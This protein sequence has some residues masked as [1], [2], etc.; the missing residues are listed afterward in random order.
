MKNSYKL[1]AGII[2]TVLIASQSFAATS[3]IVSRA[4]WKADESIRYV[5]NNKGEIDTSYEE[6]DVVKSSS[7][8]KKVI[9]EN[10]KGKEYKWPLQYP[11]KVERF[12]IHH[13]A[14]SNNPK[15]PMASIRSIYAYHAITR[16]WGDI[17]YNYIIDQNG[18]VYEGRAGGAG[19]VGGHARGYN[20][21]SIGIAILGNYQEAKVPKKAEEAL[22]N[23]IAVK[24]KEFKIDPAGY[25][26]VNGKKK[27]NVLGH[28][29]VASTV[30]PGDN[31]YEKLPSI[32]KAAAK[33]GNSSS[34]SKSTK[35][36]SFEEASDLYSLELNPEEIKEVTLKLENTGKKDWD[37]NTYILVDSNNAFEKVISFPEEQNYV[38]GK[39]SGSS[40]KSG[41]T[42]TFT[43]KIKGGE[44]PDTV[45]MK[46]TVMANG[47]IKISDYFQLPVTLN[48]SQY[49]YKLVETIFPP[50][51]MKPG[52]TFEATVKLKNM[53]N[54]SWKNAG[55]TAVFLAAD[56]ERGRKSEFVFPAG[57]KMGV[58]QEKE[59][60]PG[61]TGTF[62]M[63]LKAPTKNGLY[64]EYFT[65]V[66]GWST[67]MDDK[68]MN[69]ETLIGASD[70]GGKLVNQA[71]NKRWQ[72]GK[73]YTMWFNIKNMGSTTWTNKNFE[74]AFIKE[75]DLTVSGA[76]ILNDKLDPG[77]TGRVE[78]TVIIDPKDELG[79]KSM[80]VTPMVDGNYVLKTPI[81]FEYTTV[82]TDGKGTAE[83]RSFGT[84]T[85]VSKTTTISK[86]T[87][88][89]KTTSSTKTTTTVKKSSGKEGD[90]RI[91]LTF[92]GSPE[93]TASGNFEVKSGKTSLGKFTK[94]D[95][96]KV[97]N[98]NGDYKVTAGSKTYTK[99]SPIRF[100]PSTGSILKVN[101]F[102][103]TDNEF[104]E[105]LEVNMV[106]DELVLINELALENYMKGLAEEMN[107]TP[108][109]KIKAIIV[110]ARTY[111]KYYMDEADKFP[112]KPYN[113][114][115]SPATSQKYLGYGFE[116]RAP[117]VVKAVE[118]TKGQMV[119]Y[120]GKLVKTPY[121]SKS[122][123]VATKSAKDVWG[124]TN[125]PYLV[126][127]DDSACTSSKA[128]AGHGVGLS[129]CGSLAM[130]EDGAKYV[131]ILKHYY[132]GIEVTDFY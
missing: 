9:A 48:Q 70:F 88:T 17:G 76:K 58:I 112:G 55:T 124:W 126:S 63:S 99:S 22:I 42:G 43:F 38:L 90:I 29:D 49:Q 122:D 96:V 102:S 10:S 6:I 47:K 51:A 31:L 72:K 62:K 59:V 131:E 8:F 16:G 37:K 113:L 120:K 45:E 2:L 82:V 39:L 105:V 14:T 118:A 111:A 85:T 41:K 66:I 60:K 57:Q 67:W 108:A 5:E 64:K 74:L 117:N 40:V 68:G 79:K 19:V 65:P 15:D 34:Q 23:L 18:K 54:S 89:S 56:R 71:T 97:E 44:K 1:V 32:R 92:S 101:N 20:T 110:A 35:D 84:K 83:R 81:K 129:G 119:T 109:E 128:F 33:G 93:I 132:T 125:T 24:S 27:Y 46:I 116:K 106:D 53:G 114:E 52:E 13:T 21:G 11:K 100:I 61:E 25:S 69:F 78:F 127:V 104:R 7:L 86:T 98:D 107:A 130:A 94:N 50:A 3:G 87:T 73:S 80:M 26:T 95:K 103:R 4:G 121:F 77:K 30:C 28:R 115:D 75:A 36:Y 123:G 12:I 91:K